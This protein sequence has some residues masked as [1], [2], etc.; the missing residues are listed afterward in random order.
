MVKIF[1]KAMSNCI[2]GDEF[3]FCHCPNIMYDD[4]DGLPCDHYKKNTR[5]RKRESKNEKTD[6]V[7]PHRTEN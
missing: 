2:F 7:L 4:C 1:N 5:K 6:S 3:G